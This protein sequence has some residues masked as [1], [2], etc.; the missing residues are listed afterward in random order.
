MG[1]HGRA[2]SSQFFV[3]IMFSW[4]DAGHLVAKLMHKLCHKKQSLLNTKA[5]YLDRHS[6]PVFQVPLAFDHTNITQ[7]I[8]C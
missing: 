4:W 5:R 1:R 2:W 3:L 6:T 7:T 8:D